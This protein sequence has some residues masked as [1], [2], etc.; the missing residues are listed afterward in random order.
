[1]VI[2]R[3]SKTEAVL[4][5]AVHSGHDV[6]QISLFDTTINGEHALWGWAPFQILL[7]V[8]IGSCEE[9][10]ISVKN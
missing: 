9:Y 8:H 7:V 3:A 2:E 6:V 1:M 4:A 10:V 5:I